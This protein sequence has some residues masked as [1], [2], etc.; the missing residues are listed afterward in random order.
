MPCADL[1]FTGGPIFTAN[2][3][4]SRATAVAVRDG[5]IV[6]VGGDAVHELV[7]PKTELIDLRGRMLVPG[8]Q[9]A[10]VHPV[11]GGLDMLRCDLAEYGTAAEYLEAI[12]DFAV[13][14]RAGD[15]ATDI[16]RTMGGS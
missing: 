11:W 5:R 16:A 13:L 8:F 10:H 7:G 1:V 9:D 6:A 15:S 14:K 3:V 12:G 2:T 4:R